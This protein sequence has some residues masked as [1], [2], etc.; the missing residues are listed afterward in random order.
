MRLGLP[1]LIIAVVAIGTLPGSVKA[2]ANWYDEAWKYRREITITSSLVT[3]DLAEFPVLLSLAEDKDLADKALK[4]GEDILF[5]ADNGVLKLSHEIEYFVSS[6]GQLVAWVNVP[7]LS[8][9]KDTVIYM[10]YGNP[11]ANDQQDPAGTWDDDFTLV[12]HLEETSGVDYDSTAYANDGAYTGLLQSAAGIIDGADGFNGTG[13]NVIIP[14]DES[15][16]FTGDYTLEAWVKPSVKEQWTRHMISKEG[17]YILQINGNFVF[18]VPGIGDVASTTTPVKDTWMHVAVVFRRGLSTAHTLEIYVDGKLEN[19]FSGWGTAY[20]NKKS[21]YLGSADGLHYLAGTL[22]EVRISDTD[23]SAEWIETSFNNQSD[24]GSF[25]KIGNEQT[26]VTAAAVSTDEADPV[27]MTTATLNGF[28]TADGG[29]ACSCRFIWDT[30]ETFATPSYTAWQTGITAGHAFSASLD[31]LDK[32]THYYYRAQAMNG[33]G[34]VNGSMLYVLTRPD[35]PVDGSFYAAAASATQINLSWEKGAT[36]EKTMIRASESGYPASYTEGRQV[37]FDTGSACA[38]SG[39][40]PDTTY[41]YRA[42]SQITGSEQWSETYIEIT[43]VTMS[44][45]GS[46][47]TVGGNVHGVNKLAVLMPFLVSGAALVLMLMLG[48]GVILKRRAAR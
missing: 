27:G 14:H 42:W 39:L 8:A 26:C 23:R 16:T 35:P 43:A 1:A 20:A 44:G 12:Q 7:Y 2:E 4:Y 9:A 40:K 21:L 25:Y 11:K 32:A 41:Y 33:A 45:G 13:N 30:E 34:L 24:P 28:L 17:E 3:H 46:T 6:T 36:A 48:A 22:D 31:N 5:T 37:Y 47:V 19:T 29:E 38:D 15:L 18:Y 10:Y